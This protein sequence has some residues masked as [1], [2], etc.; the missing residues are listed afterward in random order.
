MYIHD[1]QK[2]KK[3]PPKFGNMEPEHDAFEKQESPFSRAP[4]IV[5]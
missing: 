2:Y 3:S 1:S 4:F 5:V